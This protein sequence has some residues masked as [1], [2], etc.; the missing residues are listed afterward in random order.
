MRVLLIEDNA[1]IV[2]NVHDFL[3]SETCVMDHAWD[4]VW[5]PQIHPRPA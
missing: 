4:P 3:E 2:A 5:L 1:D